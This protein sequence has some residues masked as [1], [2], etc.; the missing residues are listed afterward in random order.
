MTTL[1]SSDWEPDRAKMAAIQLP[2]QDPH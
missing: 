1:L 2:F